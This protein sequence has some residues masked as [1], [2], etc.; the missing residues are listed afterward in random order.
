MVGIELV[1]AGCGVVWCGVGRCGVVSVSGGRRRRRQ[2]GWQRSAHRQADL[3][4]A[5]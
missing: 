5:E 1:W 3:L 2:R 4:T